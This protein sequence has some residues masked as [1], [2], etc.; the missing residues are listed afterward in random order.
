MS[1]IWKGRIKSGLLWVVITLIGLIFSAVCAVCTRDSL[2]TPPSP[3]SITAPT[4]AE[5]DEAILGAQ[6]YLDGLYKPLDE[7]E[8]VQSEYYGIPLRVFFPQE[9]RRSL[10]G[11]DSS[12][13]IEAEESGYAD[14]SYRVSFDDGAFTAM[15]HIAWQPGGEFDLT[16]TPH[17]VK[18]QAVVWLGPTRLGTYKNSVLLVSSTV[19]HGHAAS[20]LASLRYTV[21]HATQQAYMY[22]T[23]RG[24]AKKAGALLHFLT[25][26]GYAPERDVRAVLFRRAT[27]QESTLPLDQTAYQ[28]CEHLPD[29]NPLAYPYHSKA[30]KALWAYLDA[31]A[32]DP[33]LQAT[34]A[35]QVLQKYQD[36]SHAYEQSPFKDLW[37][38]AD[39]P[40][41]AAELLRRQWGRTG[42]GIPSCTPFDCIDVA[43][44]IRTFVYGA[45]EAEL[46]YRYGDQTALRFA[47]AA[48]HFTLAVQITDGI[49]RM[50]QGN[51]YRPVQNGSFP[52]YWDTNGKFAPPKGSFLS[53]VT[54]ALI[55]EAS[56]PAE[57]VGI[58]PSNSETT[59]DAWAF[60][61]RYRCL[62]YH[63]GCLL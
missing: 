16:L 25:S 55:G 34:Y 23:A 11:E 3:P 45:L 56:M 61:V 48:A 31:G 20:S 47:D 33:F 26:E 4:L 19:F 38:Q 52:V 36:P 15:V 44:G 9:N 7:G 5:L 60:L 8:A 50:P 27:S 28:D 21:R 54:M 51:A 12:S 57:Y 41:A 40:K 46:G 10:L 32:R 58:A 29:A 49:V 14:E 63:T 22:W 37:L 18:R 24:D 6:V 53:G 35:L 39:T 62:K 2:L 42:N 43:S 13:T 1:S 17:D 59:F 30:C